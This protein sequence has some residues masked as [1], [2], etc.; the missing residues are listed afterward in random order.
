MNTLTQLSV[1]T[2][3][4]ADERTDIAQLAQLTADHPYLEIG[5]LYTTTPEGRNRYLTDVG[6]LVVDNWCGKGTTGLSA[7]RLGRRWLI[8]DRVMD[9]L[10]AGGERFRTFPGY[11]MPDAVQAWPRVAS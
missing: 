7:E 1:V 10:R 6:Q 3:T 9:Y 4:G 2:L 5:L 8:V 11:D